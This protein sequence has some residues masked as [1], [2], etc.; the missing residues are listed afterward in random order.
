MGWGVLANNILEGNRAGTGGWFH[1]SS[2]AEEQ[3]ALR[4]GLVKVRPCLCS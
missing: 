4:L 1:A 2:V 3:Q